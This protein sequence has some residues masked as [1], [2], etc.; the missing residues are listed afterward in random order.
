MINWVKK[1]IKKK[2]PLA[3][4]EVVVIKRTQHLLGRSA[5]FKNTCSAE[6]VGET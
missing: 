4:Q 5:V 1:K 6:E 2:K 3:R